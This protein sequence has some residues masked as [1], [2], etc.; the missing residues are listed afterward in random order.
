MAT[1]PHRKRQDA[2]SPGGDPAGRVPRGDCFYR[3]WR[4]LVECPAEQVDRC[5]LVHA[6]ATNS[7]S[8]QLMGHSWVEET[9]V[10]GFVVCHDRTPSGKWLVVPQALYYMFGGIDTNRLFRYTLDEA[11]RLAHETGNVGPWHPAL[12]T[13][14]VAYAPGSFD[15]KR[16]SL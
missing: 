10:L 3:S 12:L 16:G 14:D 6:V 15:P 5:R 9:V 13:P 2:P 11:T 8:G 1:E 4:W 7:A